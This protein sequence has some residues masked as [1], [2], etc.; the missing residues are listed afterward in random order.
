VCLMKVMTGY[1]AYCGDG[2]DREV[3]GCVALVGLEY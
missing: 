3:M 2:D 1:N